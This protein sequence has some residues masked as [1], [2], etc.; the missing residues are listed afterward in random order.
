MKRFILLSSIVYSLALSLPPN[1]IDHM[2]LYEE[3]ELKN[4]LS[5]EFVGAYVQEELMSF[6]I[7]PAKL[8][9]RPS[10]KISNKPADIQELGEE[11]IKVFGVNVP[12]KSG[13]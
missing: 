1:T 10:V 13:K 9:M 7:E 12:I 4:N 3:S 5:S 2:S 8:Q 6:Y 11:Q